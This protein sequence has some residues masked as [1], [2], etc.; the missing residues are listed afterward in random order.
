MTGKYTVRTE[1]YSSQVR[2]VDYSSGTTE[3]LTGRPLLL[4][5]EVRRW[6]KGWALI[7]QARENPARLPLLD[8]S[9]WPIA[10][11]LTPAA[12]EKPDQGVITAPPVW[13]PGPMAGRQEAV[14]IEPG[15]NDAD[16]ISNL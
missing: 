4:P 5:D 12:T 11:D 8:L 3:A 15:D 6:P 16:V 10:G 13:L 2:A 9:A 14:T 1:S 7:L